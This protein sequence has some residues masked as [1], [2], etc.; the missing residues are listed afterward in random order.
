MCEVLDMERKQKGG[1]VGWATALGKEAVGITVVTSLPMKPRG[2]P[3][4]ARSSCLREFWE[5][6]MTARIR[7]C[8]HLSG[9]VR[10]EVPDT[11]LT[12]V[13]RGNSSHNLTP[14]D[15][16]CSFMVFIKPGNPSIFPFEVQINCHH[17]EA[18]TTRLPW[19]PTELFMD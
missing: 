4:A 18:S 8:D 1:V 6:C 19:T 14:V 17:N 2:V 16:T 11:I 3:R 9:S 12:M 7:W 15:A 10:L 13:V 5:A